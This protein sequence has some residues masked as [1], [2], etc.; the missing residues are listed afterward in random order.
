MN[1]VFIVRLLLE[2]GADPN[3]GNDNDKNASI[4]HYMAGLK[5]R[6]LSDATAHL[7]LG[8]EADLDRT[9]EDGKTVADIWKECEENLDHRN[10]PN[11]DKTLN[12]LAPDRGI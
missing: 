1:L 8:S 10:Q 3:V 12:Q 6:E 2:A 11:G 9:N 4:L 7:L 5:D